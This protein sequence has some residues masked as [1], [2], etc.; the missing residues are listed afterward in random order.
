MIADADDEIAHLFD[1]PAPGTLY[2]LRPD[3]H[4]AGR[5]KTINADE[6]LRTVRL[7]LGRATRHEQNAVRG[8][9]SRL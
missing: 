7:C 5:W 6:I 2:L 1:A 3:L 4:I 9:R 8:F